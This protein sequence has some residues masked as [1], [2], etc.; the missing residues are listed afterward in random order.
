MKKIILCVV[1][2]LTV[3]AGMAWANGIPL[4]IRYMEAADACI[5]LDRNNEE[6]KT[7]HCDKLGATLSRQEH[8]GICKKLRAGMRAPKCSEVMSGGNIDSKWG[9]NYRYRLT[10]D[11]SGEG[12]PFCTDLGPVQYQPAWELLKCENLLQSLAAQQP[13][14]LLGFVFMGAGVLLICGVAL[15]LLLRA[16][17]KNTSSK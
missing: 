10:H 17:K 5:K 3:L 15:W 16:R 12:V 11:D 6:W 1:V 4:E 8:I 14:D 9:E 13:K 2:M 7:S